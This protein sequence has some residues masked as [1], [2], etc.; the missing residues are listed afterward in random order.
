M[1]FLDENLEENLDDNL[2]EI[3]DENLD[4]NL[5]DN[6]DEV[7][8]EHG[9]TSLWP[10]FFGWMIGSIDL[11]MKN[12]VIFPKLCL[13]LQEGNPQKDAKRVQWEFHCLKIGFDQF[14]PN[15]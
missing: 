9:W 12:L 6:L 5:D 13:G 8:D 2:D 11:G 4:E 14:H 15:Y 1:T 7:F 3:L 10:I